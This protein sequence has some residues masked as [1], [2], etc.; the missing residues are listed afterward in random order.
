MRFERVVACWASSVVITWG[1]IGAAQPAEPA[2][3]KRPALEPALAVVRALEAKDADAVERAAN[4]TMV[5]PEGDPWL[6]AEELLMFGRAD[7]ARSFVKAV[8]SPDAASP[9]AYVEKAAG[10]PIDLHARRHYVL[11]AGHEKPK[12][13]EERNQVLSAPWK[14]ADS[15][16]LSV[17]GLVTMN[18]TFVILAPLRPEAAPDAS[19]KLSQCARRMGWDMLEATFAREA[20]AH[21]RDAVSKSRDPARLR[22]AH[23]QALRFAELLPR[24]R[25]RFD[26]KARVMGYRD[27]ALSLL[28]TLVSGV[29]DLDDPSL[30]PQAV[31]MA[32]KAVAEIT[33]E[34]SPSDAFFG[35]LALVDALL[36]VGDLAEAARALGPL[37]AVAKKADERKVYDALGRRVN[38]HVEQREWRAAL[39]ASERVTKLA[40]SWPIDWNRGIGL[41]DQ[42]WILHRSGDQRRADEAWR[43]A[44]RTAS[45]L[46]DVDL[47]ADVLA[48]EGR[49][50][51]EIGQYD[52]AVARLSEAIALLRRTKNRAF[53]GETLVI[54]SRALARLGRW[55][56]A[57]AD[58]QEGAR[59]AAAI[60]GS[61]LLAAT[62]L[63]LAEAVAREGAVAESRRHLEEVLRVTATEERTAPLETRA[64]AL[65][66]L[67]ALDDK[68]AAPDTAAARRKEAADIRKRIA[69][70][71]G[72]EEDP[73][74]GPK[75][76]APTEGADRGPPPAT[77]NDGRR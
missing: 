7:L 73:F 21:N 74:A 37:E 39:E 10:F 60:A 41:R 38:L 34:V 31:S 11:V 28:N 76:P 57:A 30:Y 40:E 54:R 25:P 6:L 56:E 67:A 71:R 26:A 33:E 61:P 53:L 13:E 19:L 46:K 18:L 68:A 48:R 50:R 2:L 24:L 72:Y 70:R 4:P 23:E 20:M 29:L 16:S 65:D 1:G 36:F 42:A 22:I 49:A 51:I 47:E 59:I 64:R 9:A 69:S 62:R 58:A 75:P 17:S 27:A 44:Q 55:D 5:G 12:S 8:K 35:H 43:R 63:A 3:Q 52:R 66:A 15:W 77:K 14:D 45:E 32:K